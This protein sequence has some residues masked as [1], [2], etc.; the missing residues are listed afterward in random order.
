MPIRRRGDSNPGLDLPAS[1]HVCQDQDS[2]QLCWAPPD[3]E[4]QSCVYCQG[5]EGVKA[6]EKGLLAWRP[7]GLRR[8]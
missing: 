6:G 4:Q 2:G 7:M 1:Q 3:G 8:N 5:A